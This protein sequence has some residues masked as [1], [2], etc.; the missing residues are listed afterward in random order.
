MK[1][2]NSVEKSD[3]TKCRA[4]LFCCHYARLGDLQEAARLAGFPPET[5]AAEG[6]ALLQKATCRKWVASYREALLQEPAA[7]VK[8]GFE[9][10]AFGRTND[11][12]QLLLSADTLSPTEIQALDLFPVASIKRDKSGGVEV[13]FFDRLKA[14][15]SL[16]ECS[17][18]VDNKAT[19]QALL[20]AFSGGLGETE[21]N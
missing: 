3:L 6:I 7:L 20:A 17:G 9:R 14:L 11:A 13:H 2:T 18:D 19:A 8:I 21:C 4:Q 10:L 12:V 16:Y 15:S 5:A 1:Q